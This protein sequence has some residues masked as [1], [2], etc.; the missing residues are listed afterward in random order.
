M[1]YGYFKERRR[2]AEG[3]VIDS[4]KEE[5]LIHQ[6]RYELAYPTERVET[7]AAVVLDN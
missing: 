1:T 3:E 5:K 4:R 6:K 7:F 2:R